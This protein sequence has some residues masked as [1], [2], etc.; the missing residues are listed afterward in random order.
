MADDRPATVTRT[1]VN[2][3]R[4]VSKSGDD[5]AIY[6]VTLA[7]VADRTFASYRAEGSRQSWRIVRL[8]LEDDGKRL[9]VRTIRI[10]L[11]K[12]AIEAGEL[13]GVVLEEGSGDGWIGVNSD[14]E[15]VRSYVAANSA[16]FDGEVLVME[17]S[18]GS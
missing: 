2:R 9:V 6:E 15:A 12:A 8:D 10:D 1:G 3:L 5:E 18:T 4:A 13:T 17:R 16:A 7:R 14:E 11:V